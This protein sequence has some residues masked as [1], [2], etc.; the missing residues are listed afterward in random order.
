A[1]EPATPQTAPGMSVRLLPTTPR[2]RQGLRPPVLSRTCERWPSAPCWSLRASAVTMCSVIEAKRACPPAPSLD[3]VELG[4]DRPLRLLQRA[5]VRTRYPELMRH[6]AQVGQRLGLAHK[7]RG[8][9]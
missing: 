4:I 2:N 9:I 5:A 3:G 7:V 8:H 1:R 6:L